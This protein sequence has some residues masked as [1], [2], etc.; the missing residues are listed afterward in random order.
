MKRIRNLLLIGC[1]L[2][3]GCAGNPEPTP[4]PLRVVADN[5][6]RQAVAAATAGRWE[7]AAGAW[8]E[9]LRAYQSIDDWS[10]QGRARL[11]LSQTLARLGYPDLARNS[12]DG[13]VEQALFPDM[14]RVRAAYQQALLILHDDPAVSWRWLLLARSLCGVECALSVQFDNLGARLS[15][16]LGDL[17]EAQRLASL[18][19]KQAEDLPAERA[20]AHRLLAELALRDRALSLARIHLESAL[21]DD[22]LLAEPQW[23]LDDYLLLERLAN[24]LGDNRLL[25]EVVLRQK[26]LCAAESLQGCVASGAGNP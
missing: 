6:S 3:A 8:R 25:Q 7:N 5:A 2:L 17:I 4:P 26:S 9:A 22:R 15:L 13:M 10:G 1:C 24:Q 23:L 16:I 21:A 12:I 11:G 19:L 18:A 14:M 20:H